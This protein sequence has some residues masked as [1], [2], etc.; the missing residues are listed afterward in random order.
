MQSLE[1]EEM[2]DH[3]TENKLSIEEN[4]D[5]ITYRFFEYRL[6]DYFMTN[7]WIKRKKRSFFLK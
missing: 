6:G 5:G 1:I 2:S 4:R 7:K 3:S